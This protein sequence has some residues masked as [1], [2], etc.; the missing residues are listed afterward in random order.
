MGEYEKWRI[1]NI[2]KIKPFQLLEQIVD[3]VRYHFKK[4]PAIIGFI[5]SRRT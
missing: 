1:V 5:E 4:F 2:R 3:I